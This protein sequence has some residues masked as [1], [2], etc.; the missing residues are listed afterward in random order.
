MRWYNNCGVDHSRVS[1]N[2]DTVGGGSHGLLLF[3]LCLTIALWILDL[4]GAG[5]AGSSFPALAREVDYT[6]HRFGGRLLVDSTDSLTRGVVRLAV[7]CLASI[8]ES[9]V[10][11]ASLG[12]REAYLST[13]WSPGRRVGGVIKKARESSAPRIHAMV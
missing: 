1:Y 13:V 2:L 6:W 11:L 3:V 12:N 9:F 10:G 7:V 8:L 5:P 4:G